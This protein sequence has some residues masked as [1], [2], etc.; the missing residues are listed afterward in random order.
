LGSFSNDNVENGI[1]IGNRHCYHKEVK[2]ST[3]SENLY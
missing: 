3:F 1:L 2:E